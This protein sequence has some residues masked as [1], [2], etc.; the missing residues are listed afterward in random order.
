MS[1]ECNL[2]IYDAAGRL[3]RQFNPATLRMS[4]FQSI[5][6]NGDDNAGRS[7]SAGVYFVRFSDNV[8]AAT[9]KIVKIK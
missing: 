5:I 8:H 7:V 3:V 6:W 9:N 1:G 4:P 2:S